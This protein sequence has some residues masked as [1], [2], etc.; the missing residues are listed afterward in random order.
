MIFMNLKYKHDRF[1]H[2]NKCI[3]TETVNVTLK[4]K[5]ETQVG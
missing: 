3:W 5:L 1:L 4:G 2:T